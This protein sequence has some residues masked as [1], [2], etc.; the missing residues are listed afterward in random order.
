MLELCGLITGSELSLVFFS[1]FT[2]LFKFFSAIDLIYKMICASRNM[3]AS[4]LGC[5]EPEN[6]REKEWGKR[7]RGR[8]R[9]REH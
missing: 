7:G 3:P 8:G 5:I 1:T 9:H 4:V 6:E 2:F